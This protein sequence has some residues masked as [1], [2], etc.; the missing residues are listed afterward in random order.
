MIERESKNGAMYPTGASK[1]SELSEETKP[2]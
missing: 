1:T 2:V